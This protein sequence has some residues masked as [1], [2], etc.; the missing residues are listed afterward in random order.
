MNE[1]TEEKKTLKSAIANNTNLIREIESV[2]FGGI[3]DKA[4]L[5]TAVPSSG[6]LDTLINDL[7]ENNRRLNLIIEQ[8][9]ML[10]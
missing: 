8:V 1:A 6:V 4:G 10:K 2:L 5:S 3:A 7:K 9:M